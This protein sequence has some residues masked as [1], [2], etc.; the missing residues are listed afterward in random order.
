MDGEAIKRR[1]TLPTPKLPE[2]QPPQ[3]QA[4]TLKLDFQPPPALQV[5]GSANFFRR[6]PPPASV[7]FAV[8]AAAQS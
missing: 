8:W 4:P 3:L 6:P 1:L 5:V 2:V 7:A